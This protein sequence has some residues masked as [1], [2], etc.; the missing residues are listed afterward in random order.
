MTGFGSPDLGKTE[1]RLLWADFTVDSLFGYRLPPLA[2]IQQTGIPLHDPAFAQRLN[3]KL[4]K[5]PR[6]QNIPN[7]IMWLEQRAREGLFDQDDAKIFEEIITIDDELRKK[8]KQS[9]RQKFA[10]KVPFSAEIGKDRKE[11]RLW[12]LIITR[13]LGRRMDTRKIRR[14]MRQTE[15]PR[16]LQMNLHEAEQAQKA[17]KTKLKKDKANAE[18]LRKEFEK[19]VN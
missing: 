1:H 7:Q 13:I 15:Q 17:C 2:N 11:I 16:A 8:C 14:L 4:K 12:K 5:A 10:G 18:E 19:L 3:V 6:K 9:L